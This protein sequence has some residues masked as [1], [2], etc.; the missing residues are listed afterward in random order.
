MARM[1]AER[2][3]FIEQLA[4]EI[5]AHYPR[6]RLTVAVDGPDGAGKR[7]FADDLSREL[8]KGGHQTFRASIDAFHRPSAVRYRKGRSSRRAA[9]K[10]AMTTRSCTVCCSSRFGWA[11]R[12]RS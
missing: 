2:R 1:T 3:A 7:D 4:D 8:E 9:T 6:G 5:L 10:T 12:R 11:G